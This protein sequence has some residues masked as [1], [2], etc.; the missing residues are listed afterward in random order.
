MKKFSILTAAMVL[1]IG[2]SFANTPVKIV[3][4]QQKAEKKEA[5]KEDK[6]EV[7]KVPAKKKPETK[8]TKAAK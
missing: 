1:I 6:K 7:K 3:T 2:I 4:E 8:E 5:K